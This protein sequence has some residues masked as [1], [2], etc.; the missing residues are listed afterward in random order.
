MKTSLNVLKSLQI[1][2]LWLVLA[3]FVLSVAACGGEKIEESEAPDVALEAETSDD[4]SRSEEPTEAAEEE[5]TEAEQ[6]AFADPIVEDDTPEETAAATVPTEPPTEPPEESADEDV[7]IINLDELV[8]AETTEAPTEAAE[9]I[10]LAETTPEPTEPRS[11]QRVFYAQDLV[12][13]RN[14]DVTFVLT[15]VPGSSY[16]IQV[17]APSGRELEAEGLRQDVKV[18]DA[19]GSVSW[20]WHIGGRTNPGTGTIRI[21]DLDADTEYT[22]NYII[23]E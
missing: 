23:Q 1:I 11:T 22:F 3:A 15:G 9:D 20:T 7:D 6:Q 18:A 17:I 4:A 14:Q 19:N 12:G 13:F 5:V 21:W 10:V 16:K 8:D 2:L